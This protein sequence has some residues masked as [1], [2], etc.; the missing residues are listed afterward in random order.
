MMKPTLMA[1]AI[2]MASTAAHA[3]NVTLISEGFEAT[4]APAG[5]V[6]LN[7]SSPIGGITEGW[8]KGDDT[9]LAQAGSAD[10]YFASSYN[11]ASQAPGA[12]IS[13]WL[14]TSA[15]STEYEGTVSFWARSL[16]AEP[17]FDQIRFGLNTSSGTDTQFFS[18][19]ALT[20]LSGDWTQYT[21]SY[22]AKGV[23][24]QARFAI[25]Y[26]G[27]AAN[28]NFVGVDSISVTAAVPE[29]STYALMGAG[30]LGLAW[31]SRRTLAQR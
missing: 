31:R 23:G 11:V 5:W 8:F 27:L 12:T 26:A 19:S 25:E 7:N 1:L 21:V 18:L 13:T 30:L 22:D 29:P 24:S 28:A 16:I 14:L 9:F 17:Y 15:F 3:V 10:S 4:G 2:A 20:T 6:L